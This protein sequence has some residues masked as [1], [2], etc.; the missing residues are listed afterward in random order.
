MVDVFGALNTEL[1]DEI[2]ANKIFLNLSPDHEMVKRILTHMATKPTSPHEVWLQST[3]LKVG[4]TSPV[5]CL[6]CYL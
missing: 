5:L 1:A 6:V 2:L 3:N 4:Y